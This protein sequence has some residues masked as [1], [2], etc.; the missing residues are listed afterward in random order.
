MIVYDTGGIQFFFNIFKSHGSVFPF[1][2]C[3]AGPN[4]IISFIF[5]FFVAKD[6]SPLQ[7]FD[8][9]KETVLSNNAVWGGFSFLIGFLVVF[10]TSQAYSR[11]WEGC[12]EMH[13]MGAE[14]FDT[15]SS[16]CAFC[17]HA[18]PDLEESILEFQNTLIRLFSML[19]AAALG[20]IEDTEAE[21]YGMV[22]AFSMELID[23]ESIDPD[24]MEQ[25]RTEHAKVELIFTWIQQLIVQNIK[26]G[27]MSI[28]PPILSRS[29]QTLANGMVHFHE[30]LKIA[31]VPFPFPYAQTCDA[32]LII[33][34]FF[35]PFIVSQWCSEPWW[36]AM[37]S[38]IQVFTFWCLNLIALELEN[39]FGTDP[40]DIDGSRMQVEMNERL[41]LVLRHT[42]KRTPTLIT[43]E[44][45]QECLVSRAMSDAKENSRSNTKMRSTHIKPK[46]TMSYLVVWDRIDEAKRIRAKRLY[47][48]DIEG[49][50]RQASLDNP[51]CGSLD[52]YDKFYDKSGNDGFHDDLGV[53][54]LQSM[55]FAQSNTFSRTQNIQSSPQSDVNSDAVACNGIADGSPSQASELQVAPEREESLRIAT[56]VMG[57]AI[58]SYRKGSRALRPDHGP[59]VCSP[60]GGHFN[61]SGASAA[62]VPPDGLDSLPIPGSRRSFEP[63]ERSV[64]TQRE[65]SSRG[66]SASGGRAHTPRSNGSHDPADGVLDACLREITNGVNDAVANTYS[67][68]GLRLEEAQLSGPSPTSS[69]L[70]PDV[71]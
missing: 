62:S 58:D 60:G 50:V 7:H 44:Q 8:P 14:W 48:E 43:Q 9:L 63:Q 67:S 41:R 34:W 36:A 32:L 5:V 15:C 52:I 16:L 28:P 18:S 61:S 37:F 2:L 49:S 13:Q 53:I 3:F 30:A 29:F 35:V 65:T 55:G 40:N 54:G 1:A 69:G 23:P 56:S 6:D 68:M 19:H 38:F 11:F 42:T 33:H 70:A 4:A 39:P 20:Q 31:N 45:T 71:E 26:P 59:R 22:V 17:K 51:D 66:N 46:T 64:A 25:I 10:R 47:Q 27:V 21:D 24:S 12:T 57:E